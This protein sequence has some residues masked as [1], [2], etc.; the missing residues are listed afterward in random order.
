MRGR[1]SEQLLQRER[2]GHVDSQRDGLVE[3]GVRLGQH[4]GHHPKLGQV[5]ACAHGARLGR[6]RYEGAPL[7]R[8]R[9]FGR[10]VVAVRP[11]RARDAR[12]A[13][14]AVTAMARDVAV[15]ASAAGRGDGGA[16][17]V[18]LFHLGVVNLQLLH[19]RLK[20]GR[21][22]AKGRRGH[23]AVFDA[24]VAGRLQ[25]GLVGVC[26]K[27]CTC[28]VC[29][30]HARRDTLD[31]GWVVE[32]CVLHIVRRGLGGGDVRIA[33]RRLVDEN[34]AVGVGLHALSRVVA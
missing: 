10:H 27:C 5:R 14:G 26:A 12:P 29:Q 7:V 6:R 11:L 16:D 13:I 32:A 30:E 1:T 18:R 34:R 8:P 21:R 3:E 9:A 24:A 33:H 19:A 23:Q 22:V 28:S 4:V 17:G 15:T 2:A 31:A 20:S 25:A